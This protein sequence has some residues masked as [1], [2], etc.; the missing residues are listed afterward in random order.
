MKS[1][2][3]FAGLSVAGVL[4]WQASFA[5][6]SATTNNG[7]NT[8]STGTV[9][10]GANSPATALF[11][12]S[13]VKPGSTGTACVKITYTGSLAAVVKLYLKNSDLTGTLGQ[14]LTLQINEGT[15][16]A[17]DCSDFVS[18]GNDFNATGLADTTKTLS[19]FNTASNSYATGV[20][21]WAATT[22]ATKTYQFKY[23]VQDNN[24]AQNSTASATFTWEA[25]N[26]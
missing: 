12:A 16:S 5:A 11:T 13:A 23:Q 1:L 14:Y 25:Q 19:T 26:T 21:S 10:F 20:S 3:L 8:W 6:F 22:N 7:S 2:A 18:A 17:S 15:G 9:S 4:I 24:A